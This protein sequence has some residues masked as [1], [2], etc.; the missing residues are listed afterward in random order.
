MRDKNIDEM[1][2]IVK[3]NFTNIYF[4][5]INYERAASAAL[6]AERA[7]K[8]GIK[9]SIITDLKDFIKEQVNGDS[10]SCLVVAGSM[11]LL[12]EV[13]AILPEIIS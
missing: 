13:K 5:A 10:D 1:L 7:K 9:Y 2:E 11:Y 3:D 12:G 8:R 6:L 4:Y